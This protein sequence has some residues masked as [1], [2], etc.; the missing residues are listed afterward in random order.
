MRRAAWASGALWGV[1][2]VL[3]S[4]SAS[5][6][7][8][9]AD[10]IDIALRDDVAEVVATPPVAILP[11][12]DDDGDGRLERSEV[13]A[14]REEIRAALSDAVTLT[15]DRGRTGTT[16]LFDVSTPDGPGP[17]GEGGSDHLRLT[18]RVRFDE[19]PDALRVRCAYADARSITL[20]ARR[21][22]T[23]DRP[24]VLELV[25]A[26]EAVRLDASRLE[27]TVLAQPAP[28]GAVAPSAPLLP[29]EAPRAGAPAWIALVLVSAL[30]AALLFVVTSTRPQRRFD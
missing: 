8:L 15:D 18:Q 9:D 26:S 5:A 21:A 27:V 13:R 17:H 3:S 6:H 22:R 12:A 1:G 4:G 30:A 28:V 20:I 24:G 19:A 23:S 10:R 14:H 16:E 11:F 29:T 2:W 25:G 7:G